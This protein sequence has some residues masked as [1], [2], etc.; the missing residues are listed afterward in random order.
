M[1]IPSLI[2]AACLLL[3]VACSG[4]EASPEAQLSSN[5]LT[6]QGYDLLAAEQPRAALA[7]FEQAV[8][9]NEKNV[10]AWQGK[11]LALNHLGKPEEAE[12]AY[13]EALQIQPGALNVTNNLAMSKIL[14]GKYQEA[15]DLLTPLSKGKK[16]NN[17]V[18]ENLAL[19]NC[20][21]GRDDEAKKLYNKRLP[22]T[23]IQENLK[24]CK[25][26]EGLRKK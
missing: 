4:R 17:T 7:I 12:K 15:I 14:R 24:F 10:R 20:M 25:R 16:P 23:K 6:A 9:S 18:M 11:G 21:L 22:P 5:R 26:F 3:L 2:C 19:A 8:G 13:E 1:K